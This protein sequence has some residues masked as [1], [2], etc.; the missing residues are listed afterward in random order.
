MTKIYSD[1]LLEANC[2]EDR[3]AHIIETFNQKLLDYNISKSKALQFLN[4]DK[5]VFEEVMNGTSRHPSLL[6]VMKLA[7][8][9]EIDLLAFIQDI[10]MQRADH[11]ATFDNVSNMTFLLKNFDVKA[12]KKLDFFENDDDIN[13]QIGRMLA[14]FGYETIQAYEE[15]LEKPL[16]SRTKRNFSDKM[17]DF[18]IKSAYQT[19]RIIDN[20]NDYDRTRLEALIVKI[21]PYTQ[22]IEGGFLTVCRALYNVGVTV[23]IQEYLL[24]SRVTGGTFIINNK[25]CIV[26]TDSDHKYPTIW[27]TLL[28]QLHHVLCNFDLLKNH[29]FHLTGDH[30]LLLVGEQAEAFARDYFL[31]RDNFEYIER[32]INNPSL[33]SKFARENEVHVSIVY[34]LFDGYLNQSGGKKFHSDKKFYPDYIGLLASLNPLSWEDASIKETGEIIK[35][36]L[37]I[38]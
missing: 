2:I 36:I 22:D 5:L 3:E 29:N 20:P 14:F 4:I 6:T 10:L 27:I 18:W 17:K 34:S 32:F 23:I 25:P 16:Y 8:F 26:V 24:N 12:L 28:Q 13:Y 33:V 1:T 38:N 30:D 11:I 35:S 15:Q 19:F 9:M 31:S 21:K 7:Q 37:E